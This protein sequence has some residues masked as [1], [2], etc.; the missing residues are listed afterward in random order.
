MNERKGKEKRVL[1]RKGGRERGKRKGDGVRG[2]GRGRKEGKGTLIVIRPESI[3]LVNSRTLLE[4]SLVDFLLRI[5][6]VQKIKFDIK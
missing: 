5:L 1:Q 6:R 3:W 4:V 2:W